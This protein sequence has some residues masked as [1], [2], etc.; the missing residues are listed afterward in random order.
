MCTSIVSN[1]SGTVIGWNL[2][3]SMMD[4]KVVTEKDKVYIAVNDKTEGWLPLFGANSRGDFVAMPTCWPYD[5]RSDPVT[6]NENNIIMLDIDL[7][8]G[9]KTLEDVK[10]ICENK[11]RI[12]L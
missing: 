7:L 5:K 6:E 10:E 2:D 12:V 8:L 9:K 4:H 11:R 3:L 1:I